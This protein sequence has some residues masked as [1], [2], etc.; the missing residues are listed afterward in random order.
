[1]T[2]ATWVLSN[3]ETM[4]KPEDWNLQAS[5]AFFGIFGMK[6]VE[7]HNDEE[8]QPDPRNYRGADWSE[9]G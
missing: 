7:E 5:D 2:L 4:S 9:V 6:R 3:G 8:E 1:M